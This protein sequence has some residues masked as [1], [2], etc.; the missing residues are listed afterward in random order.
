ML[1]LSFFDKQEMFSPSLIL[2]AASGYHATSD[3][4]FFARFNNFI[5]H[6]LQQIVI[7]FWDYFGIRIENI[8]KTFLRKVETT[9]SLAKSPLGNLMIFPES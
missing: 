5:Y 6:F 3:L 9:K 7:L 2:Y 4:H 1:E 8:D